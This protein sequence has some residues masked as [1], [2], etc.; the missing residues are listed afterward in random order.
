[1]LEEGV[2][3]DL[4][5][6]G[7]G[8][9]QPVTASGLDVSVLQPQDQTSQLL[10]IM[11]IDLVRVGVAESFE[12]QGGGGHDRPVVVVGDPEVGGGGELKKLPTFSM[13]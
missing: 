1:M 4:P 2:E 3:V 12:V 7:V 8:V 11:N 6:G 13:F 9:S 10:H 5:V